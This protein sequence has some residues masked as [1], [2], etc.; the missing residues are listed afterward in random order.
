M[1]AFALLGG[2]LSFGVCS[3]AMAD[4]V[5]LDDGSRVQGRLLSEG[6]E[7][8]V[9]VDGG[10]VS[11]PVAE[12]QR[13]ER[14]STPLHEVDRRWTRL[15]RADVAGRRSLARWAAARSLHGAA[16]ALYREVVALSPSDREAR[17][18]LGHRLLNGRWV[19][20]AVAMRAA[21]RVRYE[22]R[23]LDKA[24]A[25]KRE[26]AF[27][28]R[29][30]ARRARD[31]ALRA[32]LR[33]VKEAE[34]DVSS[35]L[36]DEDLGFV[37]GAGGWRWNPAWVLPSGYRRLYPPGLTKHTFT[38]PVFPPATFPP[39]FTPLPGARPPGSQLP[40]SPPMNR[41]GSPTASPPPPAAPAAP[42]TVGR[43][44]TMPVFPAR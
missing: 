12:V 41:P 2:V 28:E 33:A 22:G 44:A 43:G 39:A 38:R 30:E 35:E 6:S 29:V 7:I 18:A 4:V 23:W 16:A 8:T 9:E 14:E 5:V 3:V 13:V 25:D 32:Q 10:T 31:A 15:G 21:G 1:N 36:A 24:E 17:R 37:L 40:G 26:R 42:R 20:E 11:F 27:N 19:T 34:G